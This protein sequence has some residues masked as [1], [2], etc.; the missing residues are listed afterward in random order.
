MSMAVMPKLASFR[1]LPG[2]LVFNRGILTAYHT[3]P[4]GKFPSPSGDFDF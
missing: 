4:K 3:P 1:P 2:I